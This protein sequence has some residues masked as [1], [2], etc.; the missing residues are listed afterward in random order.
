MFRR[1]FLH[2][3]PAGTWLGVAAKPG[4]HD[5]PAAPKTENPERRAYWVAVLQKLANPILTNLSDGK[6]KS[7]MPVEAKESVMA[8][9]KSVTHLEAF[10]RLMAG[11]A[12]WLA[13][14]ADATE[15]GRQRATCIALAQRCIAQAVN[16]QSPDFMNFYQ[17]PQ[18]LVDTAFLAHALLRAPAQLWTPLDADTKARVVK[19]FESSRVIQPGESNWLL[20]AAMVEAFLLS[21]GYA[22]DTTRVDRAIQKHREWYQGDGAYGDGPEFHW[23]YYNSFVIQPM[24]IDVVKVLVAAGK[25]EPSFYDTVLQ[26]ARRYAAIQERLISPEGTFPPIGRSLAYRFGAFQLLGQVALMKALPEDVS[27][28]QVRGA[29]SAV[30]HKAVEAPGT[31]DKNGWLQIGFCGHQPGLGE[32]YIS[33]GSLYLCS[34]GLLPLGLPANDPFWT[35]PPEEWTAKKV[36]SGKEAPI[37]HALKS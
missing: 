6:L 25:A 37:D 26:R 34:V 5:G 17:H 10:G 12:P 2:L 15:E 14:G 8:E 21:Q 28:A 20:F 24:L 23:D 4:H 27:P 19:A 33:T 7:A 13:L 30:I 9:R 1:Q 31:F 36:W 18:A 32:P 3:F 16:P 11:M 29:M 22:W 35:T